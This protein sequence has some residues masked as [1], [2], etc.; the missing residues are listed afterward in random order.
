MLAVAVEPQRLGGREK[1]AVGADLFVA[2]PRGPFA[3]VG[4]E[5][6]SVA[7]ARGKQQQVTAFFCVS[8]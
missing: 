5:A 4:V 3:D 8:F 2:V 7:N 6:F 1:L